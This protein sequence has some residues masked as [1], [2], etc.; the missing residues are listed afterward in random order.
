MITGAKG[1]AM[2]AREGAGEVAP[3]A[4]QGAVDTFVR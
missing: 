4:L 3:V 2:S 1:P